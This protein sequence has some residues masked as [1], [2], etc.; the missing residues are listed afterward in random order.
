MVR[1]G[2]TT[3]SQ[4][5]VRVA[6]KQLVFSV[7]REGQSMESREGG[8]LVSGVSFPSSKAPAAVIN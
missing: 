3:G 1:P 5:P 6:P 4:P 7:L 8:V 2:L